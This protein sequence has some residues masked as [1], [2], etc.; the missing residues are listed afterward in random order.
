[1][2]VLFNN[3]AECSTRALQVGSPDRFGNVL[4]V[5]GTG[6]RNGCLVVVEYK[7]FLIL[8]PCSPLGFAH[9]LRK[10]GAGREWE[11]AGRSLPPSRPAMPLQQ[12]CLQQ[13]ASWCCSG[14]CLGAKSR[15]CIRVRGGSGDRK[16]S[17]G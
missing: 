6:R 3:S 16:Q 5:H 2:S 4:H 13:P 7:A 15:A 10:E 11:S 14:T 17:L 12:P 1:M 9:R 8:M